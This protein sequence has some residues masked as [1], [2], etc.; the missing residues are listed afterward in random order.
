MLAKAWTPAANGCL[1]SKEVNLP[2]TC[3]WFRMKTFPFSFPC[4][5]LFFGVFWVQSS[6]V[7][8]NNNSYLF[9]LSFFIGC[10]CPGLNF[11]VS[12]R[13][14]KPPQ[15]DSN[16]LWGLAFWLV[17]EVAPWMSQSLWNHIFWKDAQIPFTL[18]PSA[19]KV[20]LG[21]RHKKLNEEKRG[22]CQLHQKH[23]QCIR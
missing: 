2:S 23:L 7:Q 11:L 5:G 10:M 16:D 18:P 8:W 20:H 14:V 9:H 15:C 21:A 3:F 22:E 4:L 17:L 1:Y 19:V 6:W 12:P 13:V